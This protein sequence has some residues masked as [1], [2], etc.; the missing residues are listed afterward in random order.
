MQQCQRDTTR[1]YFHKCLTAMACT[2]ETQCDAAST[3]DISFPKPE[4]GKKLKVKGQSAEDIAKDGRVYE[5]ALKELLGTVTQ[6]CP[7]S[8]LLHFGV[9]PSTNS[10]G[11]DEK[12]VLDREVQDLII[13]QRGSTKPSECVPVYV[14]TEYPH[15]SGSVH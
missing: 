1:S 12:T 6:H 8:G 9:N 13:Y 4:Y 3:K 10:D 14:Y 7:D 2:P 11:A 15:Y 5:D